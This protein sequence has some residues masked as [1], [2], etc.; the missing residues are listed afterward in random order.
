MFLHFLLHIMTPKEHHFFKKIS[1]AASE[2]IILSIL[3]EKGESHPYEINDILQKEILE[4]RQAQVKNTIQFIEFSE[5]VIEFYGD[6]NKKKLD[7]RKLRNELEDPLLKHFSGIFLKKVELD[8]DLL[9]DLEE[10]IKDGKEIMEYRGAELKVWDHV[11][12]IYQVISDLEKRNLIKESGTEIMQGRTRKLYKITDKGK[13]EAV[14]MLTIFGDLNQTIIPKA[15]IFKKN[16]NL[17]FKSHLDIILRLLEKLFPDKSI[18]DI[19]QNIKETLP[20]D[21]RMLEGMF[22]IIDNDLLLISLLLEDFI[23]K[24]KIDMNELDQNQQELF[25]SLLV[26]RLKKF[27]NKLDEIIKIFE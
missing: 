14:K 25:N 20:E 23:T 6:P 1:R 27:Q 7:I 19:F 5:K 3:E 24:D 22:P 4:N 11:P 17:L 16:I 15:L 26:N 12:S 8:K 9:I 2:F 18:S 10:L 21:S 13:V